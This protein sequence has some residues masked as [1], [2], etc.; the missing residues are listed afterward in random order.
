LYRHWCFL[1]ENCAAEY[2]A[3]KRKKRTP[4][5]K[6]EV[7]VAGAGTSYGTQT[8]SGRAIADVTA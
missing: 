3:E 1:L 4:Y 7:E 5:L 8:K 6:G 2:S